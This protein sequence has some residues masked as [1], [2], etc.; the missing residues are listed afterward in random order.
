MQKEVRISDYLSIILKWKKFLIINI[1]LI[2]IISIIVSF[3]FTVT[4]KATSTIMIPKE[5]KMMSGQLSGLIGSG[6][7]LLGG[8]LLGSS[9][10][11]TDQMIGILNS[12]SM[13]SVLVD[14]F[15]LFSYYKIKN[16][17]YDKILKELRGDFTF[18]INDNNM[19]EISMVHENPDTCAMIVNYAVKKL[20]SLNTM[21]NVLQARSNRAFME[22]RYNKNVSDLANAEDSLKKY[23]EKYGMFAVPEQ[24]EAA[25]KVI[26]ELE[27]QV[28][29]KELTLNSLKFQLGENSPTVINMQD[30]INSIKKKLSEVSSSDSDKLSSK[31]LILFPFKKIPEMAQINYRLY[32]EIQ[33]QGKIMETILPLYEKAKIDEQKSIPTIMVL[34]KAYPPEVKYQPKKALI[35]L[36]ITFPFFFILLMMLFRGEHILN[37]SEHRNRFEK[38]EF[39]FYK[40]VNH[41]YRMNLNT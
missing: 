12:R 1:I 37:N 33:I 15:N 6:G 17:N 41:F 10:G 16:K 40:W 26:A 18:D 21:F 11:E 25:I 20:D 7:S 9:S 8:G 31:S 38:K 14:Q 35:V 34:D 30:Q 2:V 3:L 5:D 19:I 27:A 39:G 4:F 22:I 28:A 36:G 29:Q 32:R 23:Q 13:M 24:V